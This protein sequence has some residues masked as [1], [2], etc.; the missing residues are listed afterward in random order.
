DLILFSNPAVPVGR[1]HMT[2]RASLDNAQTWTSSKL[3]FSGPSAYSCLTRLPNGR[4]GLFFEH[5]MQRGYEDMIFVSF[6]PKLL[7]SDFDFNKILPNPN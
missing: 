5:G 4:V 1:T 7:F 3:I 2:I 6:S